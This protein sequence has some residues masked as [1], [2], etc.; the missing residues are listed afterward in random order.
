MFV[1]QFQQSKIFELHSNY[2]STKI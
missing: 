1:A 2:M